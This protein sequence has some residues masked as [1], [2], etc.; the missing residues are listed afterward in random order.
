MKLPIL[1]ELPEEI[2]ER[3]FA[4][5]LAPDYTCIRRL[6]ECTSLSTVYHVSA[7]FAM[8][9]SHPERAEE[10]YRWTI[11]GR[12]KS[13]AGVEPTNRYRMYVN[14]SAIAANKPW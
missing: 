11:A 2:K 4:H 12:R 1:W 9:T 14:S 7:L 6:Q 13:P 5:C 10:P 8:A 3:F